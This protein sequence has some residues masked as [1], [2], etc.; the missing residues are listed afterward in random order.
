MGATP[1]QPSVKPRYAREVVA[2]PVVPSRVRCSQSD[3]HPARCSLQWNNAGW[4]A[5]ER[6]TNNCI[7][8]IIHRFWY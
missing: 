7:I 6:P 8:H 4:E 3:L 1:G 2:G 5:K